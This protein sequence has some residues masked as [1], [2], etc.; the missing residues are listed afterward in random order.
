MQEFGKLT[1]SD[2]TGYNYFGISVTVSGDTVI[3]GGLM[4][5]TNI[6]IQIQ[7]QVISIKQRLL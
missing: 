1:T 5:M 4:E 3:V 6:P 2:A 7:V